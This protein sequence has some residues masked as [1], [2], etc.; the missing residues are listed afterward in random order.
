MPSP[1]YASPATRCSRP[2]TSKA[3]L[4]RAAWCIALMQPPA[5]A[6]ARRCQ[7]SRMS[8][9]SSAPMPT[10][11]RAMTRFSRRMSRRRS[12]MSAMVPAG[13]PRKN[14]GAIRSARATPT[15]KGLSVR[16]RISQL[17]TTCSPMCPMASKKEAD[18]STRRSRLRRA[19][20]ERSVFLRNVTGLEAA[21]G[22][23][24]VCTVALLCTQTG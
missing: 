11:R 22:R 23:R 8:R 19:G 6:N 24:G 2:A 16:S 4:W 13:M 9:N 10:M 17:S 1:T 14:S 12:T 3:K 21:R 15:M 18:I 20:E 5:T 7:T